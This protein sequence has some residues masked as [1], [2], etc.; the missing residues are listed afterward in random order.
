MYL[1]LLGRNSRSFPIW[2]RS[3]LHFLV[4]EVLVALAVQLIPLLLVHLVNPV[5]H[6][7]D[8][9]LLEAL[10]ALELPAFH[11]AH[12]FQEHC[13]DHHVLLIA[14]ELGMVMCY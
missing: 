3:I 4:Q 8:H 7:L 1:Q 14:Q 6:L 11:H 9:V 10:L 2:C 5:V 12:L 13:L